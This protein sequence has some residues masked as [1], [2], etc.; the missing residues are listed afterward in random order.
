MP[1][2]RHGSRRASRPPAAR[3][4]NRRGAPMFFPFGPYE[5]DVSDLRAQK[6]S[7]L[8]NVLPR[9]DGYGPFPD[10]SVLTNALPTA[11][12]GLFF[13]RKSD[14][15]VVIFAGT[16]T[17]LYKLNNTD[18]TWTDVSAGGAA[19]SALAAADQWQFAQFNDLV[20]AVQANVVPQ[21]FDMASA[22]VFAALGGAPPQARYVSVIGRFVALSGLLS[23]PFRLQW[24]G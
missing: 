12:R 23:N 6:T 15:S 7:Q 14:G 24:S 4:S 3:H 5:P 8:A 10:L 13:A 9:A 20:V 18:Y 11:C 1:R 2:C 16:A 17:R 22:S 21:L 19:Y